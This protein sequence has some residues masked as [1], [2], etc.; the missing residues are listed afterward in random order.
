[1][2]VV[3]HLTMSLPTLC[4]APG[5]ALSGYIGTF[6]QVEPTFRELALDNILTSPAIILGAVLFF[7]GFCGCFGALLELFVLLMI[8]SFN[9][10]GFVY[11]WQANV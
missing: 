2:S 6:V 10:S 11:I 3:L 1:M 5:S 4:V 9:H 7:I 8:V